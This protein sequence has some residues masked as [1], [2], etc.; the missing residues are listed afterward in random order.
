[1]FLYLFSLWLLTQFSHPSPTSHSSPTYSLSL[2]PYSLQLKNVLLATTDGGKT[3]TDITGN[4][5]GDV[6]PMDMLIDQNE[7]LLGTAAGLY[8]GNP[9]ITSIKWQQDETV[10][11]DITFFFEGAM[12]P[13]A[14]T[15]WNG[16]YQR[17]IGSGL[18]TKVSDIIKNKPYFAL[19]ESSDKSLIAGC[20]NGMYKSEDHGKSWQQVFDKGGINYLMEVNKV[21]IA[22]S[23]RGLLRSTD[24]GAHWDFVYST[25]STAFRTREVKE[26]IVAI[27]EG[28]EF[29]GMK[30]PNEILLSK[31]NGLTWKPMFNSLPKGFKDVYDLVQVD[32]VYFACSDYGIFRSVDHG[33]TWEVTVIM[34]QDKPGVFKLFIQD[35]SLYA[36]LA[37]GC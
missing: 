12:G 18:W 9:G 37:P 15:N 13:Y 11:K 21:M 24:G 31:D 35:N 33:A 8:K 2:T 34:P 4:L 22:C 23:R 20:E 5:P 29:G 32:D 3:W 17:Q 26:G 6:L 25:T 16:L 19:I 7:Y 1:M 36:L 14:V 27:I 30:G 28:Q 10:P